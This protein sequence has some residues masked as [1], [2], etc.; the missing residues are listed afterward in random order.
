MNRY[1]FLVIF[2]SSVH[3]AAQEELK[4][5]PDGAIW[6][7]TYRNP[8][9]RVGYLT[10]EAKGDTVLND[11]TGRKIIQTVYEYNGN[12]NPDRAP[13]IIFQNEKKIYYWLKNRFTLLYDFTKQIGDTIK[14]IAPIYDFE[15][16]SIMY[17]RVDSVESFFIG[18]Q[19][20]QRQYLDFIGMGAIEYAAQ[21]GGWNSE[22]FGN[23]EFFFIPVNQLTCDSE[24]PEGLRCYNDNNFDQ[25]FV[26]FPCD[27][28][29]FLVAN[30]DVNSYELDVRT[31][32]NPASHFINIELNRLPSNTKNLQYAITDLQGQM[33]SSRQFLPGDVSR[34]PLALP[35]GIYLISIQSD[36]WLATQ[37]FIVQN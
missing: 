33:V 14:I 12:Q 16:D 22:I 30:Q 31:Y 23:E 34:I 29:D 3:L 36:K 13:I 27:T 17:F 32:P 15:D 8:P 1:I 5:A 7:Y 25:R 35:N 11:T 24:C 21:F 9:F 28:V 20:F 6:H 26:D 19:V 4:W 18:N 2:L 37:K 10:L